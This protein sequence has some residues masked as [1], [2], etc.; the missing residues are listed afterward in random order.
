MAAFDGHALLSTPLNCKSA[1][2]VEVGLKAEIEQEAGMIV[3]DRVTL[4]DTA[5]ETRYMVRSTPL[6]VGEIAVDPSMRQRL[7][8]MPD[9]R[10][11]ATQA[12][13]DMRLPIVSETGELRGFL[14]IAASLADSVDGN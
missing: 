4:N 2:R 13:L 7:L 1:I 12:K 8:P 14:D 6:Q 5:F 9:I 10:V 11:L 3:P